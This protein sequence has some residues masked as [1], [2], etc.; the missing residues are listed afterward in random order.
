LPLIC[1]GPIQPPARSA[2]GGGAKVVDVLVRHR[3]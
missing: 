2:V 3:D 1:P